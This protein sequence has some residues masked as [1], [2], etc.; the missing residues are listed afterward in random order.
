LQAEAR[1][2]TPELSATEA[3]DEAHES[4]AKQLSARLLRQQNQVHD[5]EMKVER[6]EYFEDGLMDVGA[7]P[8][9]RS[10]ALTR[11]SCPL[12]GS[13]SPASRL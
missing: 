3:D 12:N 4:G 6:L 2:N 11:Y 10:A 13:C 7:T 1:R 5:Q 9:V 8:W